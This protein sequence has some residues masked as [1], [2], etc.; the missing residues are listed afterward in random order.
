MFARRIITTSVKNS[1]SR[2]FVSRSN[3]RAGGAGHHDDHG[4]H[5]HPVI[6]LFIFTFDILNNE[7][8]T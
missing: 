4:S 3:A 1:V 7:F 2:S 6:L 5:D 8:N